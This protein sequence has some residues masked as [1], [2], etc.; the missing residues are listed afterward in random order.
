MTLSDR[1]IS[2][3]SPSTASWKYGHSSASAQAGHYS[4]RCY[5]LCLFRGLNYQ[6]REIDGQP[7]PAQIDS[8][9]GLPAPLPADRWKSFLL[10]HIMAPHERLIGTKMNTQLHPDGVSQAQM[11]RWV[12]FRTVLPHSPSG[13]PGRYWIIRAQFAWSGGEDRLQALSASFRRK[14]CRGGQ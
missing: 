5:L 1:P 4:S 12:H 2:L 10:L 9:P 7:F 3:P 6:Q 8:H 14:G 11:Q 13:F